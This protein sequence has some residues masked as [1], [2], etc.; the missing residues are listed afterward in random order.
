MRRRIQLLGYR[1]FEVC[2]PAPVEL[3]SRIRHEERTH[4][5]SRP[6]VWCSVCRLAVAQRTVV[7][8]CLRVTHLS[9]C[10]GRWIMSEWGGIDVCCCVCIA[11]DHDQLGGGTKYGCVGY[12]KQRH[13]FYRE[14]S[15]RNEMGLSDK[16][17][18]NVNVHYIWCIRR[19][20]LHSGSVW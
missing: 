14:L 7:G 17:N 12:V 10:G 18:A 6:G 2:T 1:L 11:V 20:Y 8:V 9:H 19:T 3:Q 5:F 4:K 13:R 15:H 16:Q